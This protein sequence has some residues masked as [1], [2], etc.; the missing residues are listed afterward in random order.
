MPFPVFNLLLDVLNKCSCALKNATELR[1]ARK[2]SV[3]VLI[4]LNAAIG[5]CA[6]ISV[7]RG[8]DDQVERFVRTSLEYIEAITTMNCATD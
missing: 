8:G 2:E 3:D 6:A 1:R 7:R 4:G 5:M